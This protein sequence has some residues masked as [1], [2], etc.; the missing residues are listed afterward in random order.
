M[1][2]TIKNVKKFRG[3][4][5]TGFNL[6]LLRDGK[7][8]AFVMDEGCGAEPCFEW[9]DEAKPKVDV[10]WLNF[11]QE[12]ISIL[13]CSPEEAALYES[14]RGQTIKMDNF[15]GGTITMA[16]DPEMFVGDLFEKYENDKRFARLCKTKTLFRLKG[17]KEGEWRALTVHGVSF[18]KAAKD[19]IISKYGDQVEEILNETLGQVA[20]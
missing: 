15:R 6:N 9:V 1:S 16:V 12:P 14:L 17:D 4:E 5:G 10:P 18:N 11:Q 3:M 13:R 7:K 20:V 2:Y 19:K 8:V